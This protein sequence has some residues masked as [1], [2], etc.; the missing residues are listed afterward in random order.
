MQVVERA[1]AEVENV[2]ILAAVRPVNST[3]F[4][5]CDARTNFASLVDTT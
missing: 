5:R 1:V 2:Y 4:E 3:M